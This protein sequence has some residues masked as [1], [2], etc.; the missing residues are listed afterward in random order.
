MLMIGTNNTG[1]RGG[2]AEETAAGV[3]AILGT[4]AEKQPQAKV[5]LLPIFPR[6]ESAADKKRAT[7][8]KVNEAIKGLADGK[9]VIWVDFNAKF[10]DEKGDVK[11]IMSDRLHP[12]AD[13]YRD[14]WVPAVL[15]YFKEIVG[16]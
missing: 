15:P 4:L 5:L 10:L 11:W 7:N 1:N 12:S 3:K 6:G 2:A 16:K 14:I 8:E 9:K 13:G